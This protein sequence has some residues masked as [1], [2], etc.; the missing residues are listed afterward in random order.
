V[1][2]HVGP[3]V[4]RLLDR[5]IDIPIA[6]FD[7]AWTLIQHKRSVGR[8]DRRRLAR[9]RWRSASIV[10]GAFHDDKS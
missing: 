6:V 3:G 5:L 4:Q 9:T 8:A 10:W 1:R 7:A 2:L